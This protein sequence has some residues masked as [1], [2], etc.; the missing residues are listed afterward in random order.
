MNV[1]RIFF[2]YVPDRSTHLFEEAKNRRNLKKLISNFSFEEKPSVLD[3]IKRRECSDTDDV[4]VI[5]PTDLLI[6]QHRR[7][8]RRKDKQ[9]ITVTVNDL[10]NPKGTYKYF[11]FSITGY[12]YAVSHGRYPTQNHFSWLITDRALYIY[13]FGEYKKLDLDYSSY[14]LALSRMGGRLEEGKLIKYQDSDFQEP[15]QVTEFTMS[16]KY[17]NNGSYVAYISDNSD[18][19]IAV[20]QSW[21][22]WQ[23][24]KRDIYILC[25]DVSCFHRNDDNFMVILNPQNG[26]LRFMLT[27]STMYEAWYCYYDTNKIEDMAPIRLVHTGD[28]AIEG[29]FLT[30]VDRKKDWIF[31]TEHNSVTEANKVHFCKIAPDS[32]YQFGVISGIDVVKLGNHGSTTQILKLLI[33]NDLLSKL[34]ILIAVESHLIHILYYREST[35][36]TSSVTVGCIRKNIEV[37]DPTWEIEG[38]YQINSSNS[39]VVF[40]SNVLQLYEFNFNEL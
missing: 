10:Q 34:Q 30:T 39:Y 36:R 40:G 32:E 2:S 18:M 31:L 33:L 11:T 27:T 29:Q 12:P 35:L 28:Y 5:G 20:L 21:V 37:G 7:P 26:K 6:L 25:R 38:I 1:S 13:K 14:K 22:Y 9:H 15:K 24:N 3:T 8:D 16:N 17:L 19:L 4:F 23:P